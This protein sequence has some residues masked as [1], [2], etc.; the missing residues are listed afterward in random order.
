MNMGMDVKGRNPTSEAGSYFR[1]NI[2]GW[3]ELAEYV[4]EVAPDTASKCP[5]WYYND[6]QGLGAEDSSKLADALQGEIDSGRT[7]LRMSVGGIM[8]EEEVRMSVENVQEFV[9][10]LRD[11]GGFKIW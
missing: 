6:G 8:P 10:F 1:R 4:C 7:A 5:G 3:E 2:Y 9:C 11:C